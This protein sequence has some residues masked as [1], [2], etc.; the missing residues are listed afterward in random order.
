MSS[1]PHP[2]QIGAAPAVTTVPRPDHAPRAQPHPSR[3]A[4]VSGALYTG[5][6]YTEPDPGVPDSQSLRRMKNKSFRLTVVTW[7]REVMHRR[8][9]KEN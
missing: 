1:H 5:A 9:L 4:K 3:L 7:P 6:L 8:L 2:E